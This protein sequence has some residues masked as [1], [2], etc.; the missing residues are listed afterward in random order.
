MTSLELKP[1]LDRL[2]Q[3]LGTV[4][5]CD[6]AAAKLVWC[7]PA[8]IPALRRFL[9]EGKPSGVYQPRRAAVEALGGL[10]AKDVLVE[11]LT[12]KHEIADPATRF[13]EE[14]VRNAGARALARFQSKDV[15]DVLLSFALPHCQPGIVDALARFSPLEAIP[16][17]LRAL[18]D[19]LCQAPAMEG[20]RQLGREAELALVTSALMR[21]P[22]AEE[23]RP[24][25]VRRRGKALELIIEMGP[26]ATSWPLLMAVL[27]END[28]AIVTAASKLAIVS[29]NSDDRVKAARR[30]ITVL[31]RADW[32]YREEIQDCL[33][34]LYPEAQSVVEQECI[35]RKSAPEAERIMDSTLQVLEGVRRRMDDT[36]VK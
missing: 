6:Q 22:S 13:G 15:L 2:I 30:L 1:D 23:E 14:C 35:R 34:E 4:T 3:Q 8:V 26:S 9:F 11:Y 16:Y 29:G 32:F 17:F 31:P 7:G 36:L 24:S 33:V 20:L 12:W 19:D 10:G 25:S 28:P 18:E 21:L 5:E 27:D